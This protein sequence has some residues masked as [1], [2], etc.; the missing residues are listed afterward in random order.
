MDVIPPTLE[1]NAIVELPLPTQKTTPPPIPTM[2]Y[3][4][5]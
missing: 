2:S 1:T 4:V 3:I 5:S